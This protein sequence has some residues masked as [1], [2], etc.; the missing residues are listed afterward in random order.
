MY[1]HPS[2]ALRSACREKKERHPRKEVVGR[3]DRLVACREPLE[4]WLLE[5]LLPFIGL[6]DAD[7]ASFLA[8]GDGLSHEQ[9]S[10]AE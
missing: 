3:E 5:T 6:G 4:A 7:H 8:G 10:A 1:T 2:R 9:R